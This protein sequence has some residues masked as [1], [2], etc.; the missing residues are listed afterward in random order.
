MSETPILLKE[1]EEEGKKKKSRRASE[2]DEDK[3]VESREEDNNGSDF[4][5]KKKKK[6][7]KVL[8]ERLDE[9]E[10]EVRRLAGLQ[11]EGAHRI[12]DS[13]TELSALIQR[14]DSLRRE[15]QQT[16]KTLDSLEEKV[17]SA[18]GSVQAMSS[19]ILEHGRQI[20]EQRRETKDALERI[21]S[22]SN[23]RKEVEGKESRDLLRLRDA[24]G[25][26]EERLD[27]AFQKIDEREKASVQ[28]ERLLLET[29]KNYEL[30]MISLSESLEREISAQ[31]ESSR[32]LEVQIETASSEIKGALI[33]LEASG[34]KVDNLANSCEEISDRIRKLEKQISE[35]S[36]KSSGVENRISEV[37]KRLEEIDREN[38]V[39]SRALQSIEEL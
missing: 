34:K 31:R 17:G 14:F 28:I 12:S 16:S 3:G 22:L 10:I 7:W 18:Q 29:Q 11:A 19:D 8:S 9:L 38:A 15:L 35:S 32:V 5:A 26:L 24:L 6:K 23:D 1:E 4:A 25:S 39:V 36:S 13:S 2:D 37:V 20:G 27:S 30:R 21:A 33:A